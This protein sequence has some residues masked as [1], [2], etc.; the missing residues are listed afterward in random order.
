M[1]SLTA[2][3][4]D[5]D[6]FGIVFERLPDNGIDRSR[7]GCDSGGF[8]R[9]PAFELEVEL[10]FISIA[11]SGPGRVREGRDNRCDLV[12]ALASPA[13]TNSVWLASRVVPSS[14]LRHSQYRKLA[15]ANLAVQLSSIVADPG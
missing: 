8:C 11:A 3:P 2:D 9:L 1:G 14:M 12:R 13:S 10:E 6:R 5:C 15:G 7:Q 4:L